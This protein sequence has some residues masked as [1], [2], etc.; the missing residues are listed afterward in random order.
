MDLIYRSHLSALWKRER[1]MRERMRD[2]YIWGSGERNES[3]SSI[4][5]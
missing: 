4:E 1:K 5:A 3:P 2:S